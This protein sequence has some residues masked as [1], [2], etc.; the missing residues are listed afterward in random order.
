MLDQEAAF[1]QIQE[2]KTLVEEDLR[3]RLEESEGEKE[4]LQKMAAAAA[5]LEQQLEQASPS[6]GL[7]WMSRCHT[8]PS[9]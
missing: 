9:S 1:V 7:V 6:R 4:Q 3:R 8:R 5:A 2:A